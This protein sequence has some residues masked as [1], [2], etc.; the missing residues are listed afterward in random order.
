MRNV[1]ILTAKGGN[2]SVQN[3]NVIPVLGTPVILS[4][5]GGEDVISDR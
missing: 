5:A 1:V 4:V 2:T 3:K